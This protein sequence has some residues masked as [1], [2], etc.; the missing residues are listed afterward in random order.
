M[1]EWETTEHQTNPQLEQEL[2]AE[3]CEVV[4]GWKK[5]PVPT[6]E[7]WKML[8][9]DWSLGKAPIESI[10]RLMVS[11][12]SVQKAA[13]QAEWERRLVESI[14]PPHIKTVPDNEISQVWDLLKGLSPINGGSGTHCYD[15]LYELGDEIF[16]VTWELKGGDPI[17]I[18]RQPKKT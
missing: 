11:R 14:L 1:N 2:W 13:E 3:W 7:E 5:I 8:R 15:E 18:T 6:P 12:L 4:C 17:N 16:T 9:A 10:D